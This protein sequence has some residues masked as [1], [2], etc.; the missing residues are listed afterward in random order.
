M[1]LEKHKIPKEKKRDKMFGK[2]RELL[3]NGRHA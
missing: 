2:D 3:L 1:T